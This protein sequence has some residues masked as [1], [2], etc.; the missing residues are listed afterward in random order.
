MFGQMEGINFLTDP[1]WSARATPVQFF[2]PKRY[3]NPP[4]ALENLPQVDLVLISHTH[5]DHLDYGSVKRLKVAHPNAKYIVPMG[6]KK[7]FKSKSDLLQIN[8]CVC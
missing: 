8:I 2:G 7:W 5:Y 1:V 3:V 4:I 6:L